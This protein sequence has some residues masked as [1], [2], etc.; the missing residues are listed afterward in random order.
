MTPR[1]RSRSPGSGGIP[2]AV[3]SEL[4]DRMDATDDILVRTVTH[5]QEAMQRMR[6]L[7]DENRD[8]SR[9]VKVLERQV[10]VLQS[11]SLS[12]GERLAELESVNNLAHRTPAA[13]PPPATP[14]ALNERSRGTQ[15]GPPPATPSIVR[16]AGQSALMNW[17]QDPREDLC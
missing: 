17:K 16:R 14:A 13:G 12:Y 4:Q 11:L 10:G 8:L 5:F 6:Q 7:E 9:Q 2:P 15:A 1:S 3:V